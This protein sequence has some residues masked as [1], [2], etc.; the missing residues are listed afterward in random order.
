MD[1]SF[2]YNG[3]KSFRILNIYER[4]QQ[5]EFLGK[6][7][8]AADYSVTEKT[9]Q[10]D[11]N[12]LR[13]YLSETHIYDS[14][15]AIKYD[16]VLNKYYLSKSES[17]SLSN[18]EILTVCKLIIASSS[19]PKDKLSEIIQKMINVLPV[20][21]KA[22][23]NKS[24]CHDLENYSPSSNDTDITLKVWNFSKYA[25]NSSL[26]FLS[27]SFPNKT[28]HNYLIYPMAVIYR[29]NHFFLVAYSKENNDFPTVFNFNEIITA[30]P[31]PTKVI[32]DTQNEI[33]PK[34]PYISKDKVLEIKNI[35]FEYKGNFISLMTKFPTA[36][37]LNER[38]GIYKIR[39]LYTDRSTID[40]LKKNRSI[41]DIL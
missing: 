6:S 26:L 30:K 12:D 32:S 17:N 20:H 31:V 40:W 39:T 27:Y 37:L 22:L 8:L 33:Y 29:K 18:D 38:N 19:L 24:V 9:I 21:D 28:K 3:N 25:Q 11:I 10:R 7:E 14:S 34:I 16:K 41:V 15:I 5:G 35:D 36:R 23:I 2:N 1:I 13:I 4:L